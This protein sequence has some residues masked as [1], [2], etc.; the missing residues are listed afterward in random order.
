MKQLAN[1]LKSQLV[2][3]EFIKVAAGIVQ[4]VVDTKFGDKDAK[5]S[6]KMPV[7]YDT[8]L[9]TTAK[10]TERQL[11]PDA[12]KKSILYFEDFGSTQDTAGK[13]G[14]ISLISSIRLVFWCDKSKIGYG[15]Y[16]EVTDLFI[17]YILHRLIKGS[18]MAGNGLSRVFVSNPKI[19]IQDAAIFSRYNYDEEVSQYLRPPFEYFAIDL[20]CK[21]QLNRVICSGKVHDPQPIIPVKWPI[22][23]QEGADPADKTNR[24]TLDNGWYVPKAYPPGTTLTIPHL[25]GFNVLA[26]FILNKNVMDQINNPVPYDDTTATWDVGEHEVAYFND[27]DEI[28][29]NAALPAKTV[30]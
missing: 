27:G 3:L 24:Q 16:D 7:S 4:P 5:I 1:L 9:G 6:K 14:K 21:Y 2:D 25:V 11:V 29:I 17:D 18:A 15:K 20:T 13:A 30:F 10:G 26:P 28:L 23:I 19:L 22:L 8:T 12:G